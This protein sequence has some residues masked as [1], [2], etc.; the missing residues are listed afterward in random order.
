MFDEFK[1]K[2]PVCHAKYQSQ[3]KLF[4]R[5][6]IT[7]HEGDR[8]WDLLSPEVEIEHPFNFILELKDPCFDCKKQISVRVKDGKVAEFLHSE[9]PDLREGP[10]GTSLE[11]GEE[12]GKQIIEMLNEMSDTSSH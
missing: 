3:T 12:R 6:G 10:F 5:E 2:C 11:I 1:G 7:F 4:V 9:W 8:I